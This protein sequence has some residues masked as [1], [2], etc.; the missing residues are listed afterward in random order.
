VGARHKGEKMKSFEQFVKEK[1]NHELDL[2]EGL[3]KMIGQGVDAVAGAGARAVN[4]LGSGL[5]AGVMSGLRR[6]GQVLRQGQKANDLV[7]MN[8]EIEKAINSRDPKVFAATA[9][10][11]YA[12]MVQAQKAQQPQQAPAEQNPQVPAVQGGNVQ[13]PPVPTQQQPV[14][15]Q[16]PVGA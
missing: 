3:G 6:T 10:K 5:G 9:K 8:R 16:Q 13:P 4:A 1:E 7:K 12:Q 14:A 2:E 15:Q 11:L